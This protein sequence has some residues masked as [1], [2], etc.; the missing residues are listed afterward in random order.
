MSPRLLGGGFAALRVF[1]GAIW[2]SNGLAKVF[3]NQNSNFD[4]GFVSFNLINRPAAKSILEGASDDTFQPLRWIYHDF[5]L[6]NW[7]L[8][9][10]FLTIAEVVAGL[11]LLL[12]VA[13]RL[14][15]LIGLMLIGPVWVMLLDSNQYFWAYP[16]EL[17]PLLVL[18]I[19]PAGRMFGQD[20]KL[21][22]RYAG[23]WPF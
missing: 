9:Q 21:A 20:G 1:F 8:F 2:L 7:G 13:A 12:G 18:A 22:T 17:L 15:A 6:G 10:W 23:R 11:M 5:V 16:V 3:A 14:G 4:W 19:V